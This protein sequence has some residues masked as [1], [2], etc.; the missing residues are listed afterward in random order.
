MYKVAALLNR[1]PGMSRADFINYYEANHARLVRKSFP[2]ILEYRR[3]FVDLDRSF[4]VPGIESPDFDVITEIWYRDKA[5]YKEMLATHYKAGL[6]EVIEADERNFMDQTMTRM[7][8]VEEYGAVHPNSDLPPS[9]GTPSGAG[10][11]KVISLLTA[12]A[13]MPRQEYIDYYENHHSKLIWSLFPWMVEYRRNH[14]DLDGALI[15]PNARAPGFST[16]T[17]QWFKNRQ[18]YEHM[19]H[20]AGTTDAGARVGAD[21]EN[22]F[23][24]SKTRFFTV[25]EAETPKN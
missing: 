15:F 14:I 2:L 4:I 12:K 11:F 19:L 25:E 18:D 13:G 3:N 24:R 8:R 5:S 1:K 22:C 10:L 6:Q 16:V 20:A 7:F 9:I 17:E 21:E 23:D